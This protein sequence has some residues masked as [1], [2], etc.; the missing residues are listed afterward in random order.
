MTKSQSPAPYARIRTTVLDCPDTLALARFYQGLLGGRI[1]GR[2]EQWTE[3]HVEGVPHLSFQQAPGYEPPA[4]PDPGRSQQLHLDF[5][6]EDIEAAERHALALGAVPL[7]VDDAGG[8]R[9]FR[10]YADPAG[11]P[12]CLIRPA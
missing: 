3:L 9:R 10:V 4:W 12:F 6:V 1:S 2:G 11:H 7:D 5:D 8:A